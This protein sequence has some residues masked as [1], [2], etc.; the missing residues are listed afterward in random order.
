MR[1]SQN[2]VIDR[3]TEATQII[4]SDHSYIHDKKGFSISGIFS[5]VGS[6]ATVN[7]AFKTPTAASGKYIH[8]KY[9]EYSATANRVTMVLYENPTTAPTAGTAITPINRSRTGT[10]PASGM[11]SV[12]SGMTIDTTGSTT[13]T[14]RAFT[15]T[16]AVSLDIEFVLKP[17]TWYIRTFTNS[18]GASADISYFEFWYEE[19]AG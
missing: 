4:T 11:Q 1:K 5:G 12:A 6:G 16:T 17:D 8:L 9:N 19:D 3:F 14:T 15:S 13:L 18:T 7:Y 10:I 2:A